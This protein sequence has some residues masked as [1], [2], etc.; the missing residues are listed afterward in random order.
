MLVRELLAPDDMKEIA[1]ILCPS[2]IRPGDY[3]TCKI[4]IPQ[5]SQVNIKV[6]LASNVTDTLIDSTEWMYVPGTK[7]T[8]LSKNR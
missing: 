6:G 2:V 3:F 1:E 8:K 4:D 7:L 5:G